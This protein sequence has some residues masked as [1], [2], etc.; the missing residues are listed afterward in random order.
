M[1]TLVDK[2]RAEQ[3]VGTKIKNLDL[4]QKAFT[5]KSA[6]KEY[7][8]FTESFETL[9]FI[10]DSVL[11][12]VITKFLFDR[13]ESRQ[14]GFLTKART[15]LV[16][17]ETLARIANALGL[18]ELVVMDEKG[19]RNGWNNN[20]KILEDVFEALIGAIYM[21]IGLIHAKEFILRIYQDPKLVDLNSIMVDDNYKD[22]LMRHC[23]VNNW[24][25]PEYRVAAHHEGLFYIDIYINNLF[26]SRGVAK[27][28]KQ[29]EQN[30]AQIYFQVMDELKNYNLN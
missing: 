5:H 13:F 29:A 11:G 14:E 26:C 19:M 23:Q 20:P 24:Q 22:H 16:R 27:S 6:L 21:D 3:L 10:G 30:A 8:Q 17:G 12:F 7:E 9:E 4:Y 1:V 25:L 2:A 28:K 18:N 15:K